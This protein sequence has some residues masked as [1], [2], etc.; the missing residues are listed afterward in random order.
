MRQSFRYW[1]AMM[2]LLAFLMAGCIHDYPRPVPGSP[3]K[4]GTDPAAIQAFIEVSYELNWENITHKIDFSGATKSEE[5]KLYR[6]VIE[7]FQ[8]DSVVGRDEF[9][10]R[11]EQFSLGRLTHH[12][13]QPLRA[14]YY[15]IAV[16]FDLLDSEGGSVFENG[17]LSEVRHLA[18]T[19]VGNQEPIQC[20]FASDIIDLRGY[21][22][23][24]NE[25]VKELEMRH[26]GARF[27]I[28]ATDVE[29]FISAN[30][31][32][33]VQGEEYT[34]HMGFSWPASKCFSLY[35]ENPVIKENE[36]VEFTGQLR[37]PYAEYE[38]LKIG[39]GFIFCRPEDTARMRLWV[40]DT[41]L[42]TVA[43]TS[44]F[45]FPIKRGSLTTI[46]GNFLTSQADG[47]L[48]IDHV[49]EGEIVIDL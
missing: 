10:V 44:E 21:S 24:E 48:S 25:V 32:G 49:W 35:T 16:W 33:L 30:K 41:S 17:N 19:T 31:G 47:S 23:G 1:P 27:E 5:N 42:V 8:N 28:I 12:L 40:T 26:P 18:A 45:S 11:G 43:Q 38:E 22:E 15:Q 3:S 9:H 20:G 36:S 39:E 37:L 4:P 7:I 2:L 6:F 13:S 29:D 46:S 14:D 34:I